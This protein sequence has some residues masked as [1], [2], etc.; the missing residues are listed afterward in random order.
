MICKVVKRFLCGASVLALLVSCAGSRHGADKKTAATETSAA[1]MQELYAQNGTPV[2][3]RQLKAESFSVY[4][5]YPSI[6]EAS[7]QATAYAGISDV[8]R[9]ISVKVGDEVK[10]DDVIVSFS[11]DNAR[12]LQARAASNGADTAFKRLQALYKS[13]DV[14]EQQYDQARSQYDQA[15][16]ALKAVEDMVYVKAPISGIITQLNARLNQNAAAGSPLFTVTNKGGFEAKFYV[17]SDEIEKINIGARVYVNNPPARGETAL[18]EGR[19]TQVSLAMDTVR[20]AFPVTA[21]FSLNPDMDGEQVKELARAGYYPGKWIN[22]VVETYHNS[23]ALV[24][25]RTEMVQ[26][27]DGSWH[28]YLNQ[29]GKAR[30]RK[31]TVGET[32][33]LEME[34]R[35]GLNPGDMLISE[36]ASIVQDGD[37]LNVVK[38]LL[39]AGHGA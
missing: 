16:A 3:T 20:Q 6:L 29:D 13:H 5:D 15:A 4:L 34:I 39:A 36:G 30:S 23:D 7:S 28:A 33:G 2:S 21:S 10:R 27:A 31:L 17:G 18:V 12:L 14:S 38:P 19:I 1:S 37:K 26:N 25:S 9:K 11:A 35:N 24:L 22:A 8:V 32:S